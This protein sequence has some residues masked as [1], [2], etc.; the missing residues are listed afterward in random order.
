M[1]S[2]LLN[3]L[4]SRRQGKKACKPTHTLEM[5]LSKFPAFGVPEND[6]ILLG[7]Y[8]DYSTGLQIL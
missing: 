2:N 5:I 3:T 8:L 6:R 4:E 1:I 7:N